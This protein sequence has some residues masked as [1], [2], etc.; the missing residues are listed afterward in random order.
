MAQLIDTST[1]I[2]IERHGL[3]LDV[4]IERQ[5]D[6]PIALASITAS[7]LLTGIWRADSEERRSRREAFVE[8]VLA[9]IPVVPFDLQIARTHAELWARLAMA[10]Q[11]I[12]AYDLIIAATAVAHGYD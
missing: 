8:Q 9:H 7:E 4:L 5:A 12:G 10:G 6:E 2:M 11:L 3:G 1:L